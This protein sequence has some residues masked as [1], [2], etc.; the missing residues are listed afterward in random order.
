MTDTPLARIHRRSKPTKDVILTIRVTP[1]IRALMV[2]A[3]NK[4]NITVTE[5]IRLAIL[6]EVLG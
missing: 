2:M 6:S 1:Q 3:A 4:R 5:F